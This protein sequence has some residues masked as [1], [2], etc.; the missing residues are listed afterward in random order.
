M[1]T[2]FAEILS[3]D[4]GDEHHDNLPTYSCVA[5]AF[6]R[7]RGFQIDDFIF[8]TLCIC[9]FEVPTCSICN[10]RPKFLENHLARQICKN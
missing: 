6:S 2:L 7:F 1:G 8:G 10:M 3:D 9:K 4:D 5:A